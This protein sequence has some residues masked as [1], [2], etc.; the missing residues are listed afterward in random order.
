MRDS[1][2]RNATLALPLRE[3]RIRTQIGFFRFG[4]YRLSN[5]AKAEFDGRS[6]TANSGR[7]NHAGGS[8]GEVVTPPRK[9]LPL[10]ASDLSALPQGEGWAFVAAAS[11]PRSAYRPFTSRGTSKA[12]RLS[13][14]PK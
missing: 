14:R 11:R 13:H 1:W 4:R 2:A 9:S 3:G 8:H 7:G 6:P 10:R 12:N 5:S